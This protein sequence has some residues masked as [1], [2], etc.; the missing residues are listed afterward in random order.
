MKLVVVNIK[1]IKLERILDSSCIVEKKSRLFFISSFDYRL[2]IQYY[3]LNDGNSKYKS[4]TT[5]FVKRKMT[6]SPTFCRSIDNLTGLKCD[7][8]GKHSPLYVLGND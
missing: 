7:G 2:R 3:V 1:N 6:H 4:K 5:K 8:I